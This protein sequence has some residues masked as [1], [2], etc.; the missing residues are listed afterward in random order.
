MHGEDLLV[1]DSGH[2]HAVE[3]VRE[4]LP[5]SDVVA[6]LALVIEAVDAV[7][8]RAL[9]VPTQDEEILGVLDLEGKDQANSLQGLLAAVH[10][11]T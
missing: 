1:D 10:I 11:V 6:P 4:G 8:R 3:C 7:D 5:D 9:M 2:G